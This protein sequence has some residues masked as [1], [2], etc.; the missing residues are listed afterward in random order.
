MYSTCTCTCTVT[1][2]IGG[3]RAITIQE[4]LQQIETIVGAPINRAAVAAVLV[5]LAKTGIEAAVA[6]YAALEEKRPK[7]SRRK[8]NA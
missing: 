7:R 5:E 2:I 1:I 3:S 6:N 8:Q 4:A